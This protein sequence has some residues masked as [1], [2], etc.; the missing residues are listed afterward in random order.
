MPWFH[1]GDQEERLK[2]MTEDGQ[3]TW[4][5]SPNDV[6]AIKWALNIIVAARAAAAFCVEDP[7]E[8]HQMLVRALLPLDESPDVPRS[9]D[10]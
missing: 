3:Q 10:P 2:A 7:T 8:S 9:T 4:D 5:L 1:E 6:T